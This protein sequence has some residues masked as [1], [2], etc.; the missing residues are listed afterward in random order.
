[1]IYLPCDQLDIY[2]LGKMTSWNW[3]HNLFAI[4]A[5]FNVWHK[6]QYLSIFLEKSNMKNF[7]TFLRST[8][9]QPKIKLIELFFPKTP[10]KSNIVH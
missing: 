10:S 3:L 5:I 8:I 1:M 4:F 9:F 7:K 2:N 6:F